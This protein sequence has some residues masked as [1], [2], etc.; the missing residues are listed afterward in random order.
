ME[1]LSRHI[2]DLKTGWFG[3][4]KV[5]TKWTSALAAPK[6][7]SGT[8]QFRVPNGAVVADQ[9]MVSLEFCSTRGRSL[10]AACMSVNPVVHN[11]TIQH[12][13]ASFPNVEELKFFVKAGR[14]IGISVLA[15]QPYKPTAQ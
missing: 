6:P 5:D 11:K 2:S 10:S 4:I 1:Y 9:T 3:K 14:Y 13:C 15:I 8:P 12:R 7:L